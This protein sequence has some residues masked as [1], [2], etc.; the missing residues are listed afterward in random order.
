[1]IAINLGC[2]TRHAKFDGY[3]DTLNIDLREDVKPDLIGDIFSIPKDK[4]KIGL[5]Y[6]SH[7]LE[8]FTNGEGRKML[9]YFYER[10]E[11][12]GKLWIKVP[13][14]EHAAIQILRDGVPDGTSMDILYGHQEYDTNFHKT[15]F[16]KRSLRRFIDTLGLFKIVSCEDISGGF[17]IE[18][19]AEVK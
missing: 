18:L 9:R 11:P 5:I 6:I 12:E 10:L 4:G 3:E 16:T 15:G 7:V 14:L 17:E 13:S 1:M 19:K 8:H 2:G